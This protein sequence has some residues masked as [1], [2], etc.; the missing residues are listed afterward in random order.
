M[1]L[2]VSD[3]G[4][5]VPDLAETRAKPDVPNVSVDVVVDRRSP[6]GPGGLPPATAG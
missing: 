3:R 6:G 1:H 2:R 4:C 5:A